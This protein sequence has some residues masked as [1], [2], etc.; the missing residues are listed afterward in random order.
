MFCFCRQGNTFFKQKQYKEAIRA[1]SEAID[2]DPSDVTF[3]SNRSACFAA[4]EEWEKAADDGRQ[5]IITDRQFV[6]GYYRSAFALKNLGNLDGALDAVKR[7]L[8]IDSKNADLKKMSREIEEDIRVK[9]VDVAYAQAEKQFSENDVIGAYKNLENALRLDPYN[10]KLNRL[11]D[12]VRP[13]YE[14][15]EKHRLASLD[16]KERIKEEGDSL[17]KAAN[18]EGAIKSYTKCLDAI[19]DKVNVS[20]FL[21]SLLR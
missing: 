4:L 12:V 8:G 15:A 18:F 1:Y 17:F 9:K 11:M 16:P 5:C 20:S 6:K 2:L 13:K 21:K 3:Y 19:S 10:S 7:G 14:M